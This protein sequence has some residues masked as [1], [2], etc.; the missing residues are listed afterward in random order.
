MKAG[1]EDQPGIPVLAGVIDAHPKGSINYIVAPYDNAA[2]QFSTFLQ[3]QGRTEIGVVGYAALPVFFDQIEAGTL[4]GAQ[5]TVSIPLEYMGYAAVDEAARMLN[6]QPTWNANNLAV[7]L[8][9]RANYKEYSASAPWVS[10][11][12]DV[13]SFF[14]KLWGKG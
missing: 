12:F 10:P 11:G 3:Q 6:G 5:A 2:A 14:A 9:T 1:D 7:S 4:P 13:P 8:V